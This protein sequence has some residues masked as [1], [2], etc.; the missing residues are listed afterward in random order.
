EALVL[1]PKQASEQGLRVSQDGVRR[2]GFTLL[3]F[4]DICFADLVRIQPELGAIPGPIQRQIECDALYA[5][6]L[7]R[8]AADI[9]QVRRDEEHEIPGD[10]DYLS[11]SGLSTELKTK[12]AQ[13]RPKTLAQA[14]RVDGMTPA[15]LTLILARLRKDDRRRSAG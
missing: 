2:N 7:D 12:L 14:G 5:Q 15:A 13:R 3:S 1:T 8:Q 9:D 10:F 4:P 11:I 6:Y